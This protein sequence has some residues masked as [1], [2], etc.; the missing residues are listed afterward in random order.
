MFLRKFLKEPVR[1]Q[2]DL[3]RSLLKRAASTEW[4]RR[5][6]FASIAGERDVSR[7]Y[8]ET[9][10]LHAYEDK[11]SSVN[12]MRAGE[13]NILWPGRTRYFAASSGTTS[14]GRV[15]PV[16]AEMLASNRRFSV[17]VISNYLAKTRNTN[18][19]FGRHLSLPGWIEDDREDLGTRI[20]Q[21]SAVLAESS[22]R[23]SRPW[24]ALDNKLS[25]IGDWE[26]KMAAIADHVLEQDVRL[27]VIAPSWCQVL[28]R[29]VSERHKS[30]TGMLAP[31]GDIWPNLT[32]VIT[33]GVALSGYRDL[34]QHHIGKREV[35]FVETYGASEGFMAFQ[36]DLD[37]PA[38]LLHLAN[39]VYYEFVP[40]DELGFE[41]P[42]RLSIS[43]VET[44]VRYVPH[45]TSN[46]GFWS[47]CVG[48]V[49]KFTSLHPHKIVVAGRTVDMLDKYGEAVFGDE[50]H[51]ALLAASLQ[52]QAVVLNYHVTHTP[53]GLEQTP[54]HHW[55]IEFER[56]PAD[57]RGFAGIIDSELK[58]AGHHYQDRREGLA[59]DSPTVTALKP[60][61]FL[62]WMEQS[63]KQITVQTKVPAMSE[64]RDFAEEILRYAGLII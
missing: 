33:G 2:D 19:L 61:T 35:D 51:A 34:L 49:V 25:F 12:R 16:S 47:Y 20:G 56:A 14:S 31:I 55:L 36:N 13:P 9:V 26:E 57:L 8:R 46:S 11:R 29:L 60:G 21:I 18:I 24:R 32:T 10:P 1:T 6:D 30:K 7:A 5:F 23:M 28:F 43:E 40:V 17:S 39:G 58:N 64:E 37:D 15:V 27:I 63:G 48:D 42:A 45:L 3:L 50:A 54:A 4:G 22:A 62:S 44:G 52:T 41:N 38:M 53:P 59:F